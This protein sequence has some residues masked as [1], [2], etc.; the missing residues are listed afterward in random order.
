MGLVRTYDGAVAG[1]LFGTLAGMATIAFKAWGR[2]L[3][4]VRVWLPL[5]GRL[6]GQ[7]LPFLDGACRRGVLR[8]AGPVYQFRHARIQQQLTGRPV[9]TAST[10]PF[11]T[12]AADPS[13][14]R[15]V[16]IIIGAV[17]VGMT[18]WATTSLLLLVLAVALGA[19]TLVAACCRSRMI[20]TW[21]LTPVWRVLTK[22]RSTRPST[23]TSCRSNQP[24]FW[25]AVPNHVARSPQNC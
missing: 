6:P 16:M 19:L 4:V 14:T 17:V 3:L 10:D 24:L 9:R 11:P 18:S 20:S 23:S 7:I 21:L 25:S 5:T 15:R 8:Q 12:P 1:L 22:A 2:W 13:P